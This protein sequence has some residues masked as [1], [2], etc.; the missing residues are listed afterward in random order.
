V[1]KKGGMSIDDL[2]RRDADQ[3]EIDEQE[4][5][6]RFYERLSDWSEPGSVKINRNGKLLE[7]HKVIRKWRCSIPRAKPK[8]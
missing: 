6:R 1:G 8:R 4:L 2:T 5:K 3:E 7:P